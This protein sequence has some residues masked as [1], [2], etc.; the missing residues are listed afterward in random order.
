MIFEKD[1]L[2]YEFLPSALEIE[3]TP[4][5]PLGR[6]LI[7]VI[8]I[9]ISLTFIWSYLG[10]VDQVAVAGGKIIPDGRVKVIQPM[11]EGVITAEK[12]IINRP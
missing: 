11:E 3:K 8:F 1:N 2:E 5:S 12:L 6:V 7:W 4:S 10:R 9:I